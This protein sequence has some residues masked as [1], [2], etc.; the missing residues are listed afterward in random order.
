MTEDTLVDALA[1]SEQKMIALYTAMKT[2]PELM[3][4]FEKKDFAKIEKKL[5]ET[6]ANFPS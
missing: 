1:Q 2:N 4:I 6:K 5:V 3:E